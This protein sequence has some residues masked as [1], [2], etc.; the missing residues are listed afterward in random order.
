[1]IAWSAGSALPSVARAGQ[2]RR[3]GGTRR[4][5]AGG[6]PVS[7]RLRA[8]DRHRRRT[9]G[10]DRDL[11][12]AVGSRLKVG[13]GAGGGTEH[14]GLVR[15][16]HESVGQRF[17]GGSVNDVSRERGGRPHGRPGTVGADMVGGSVGRGRA[18]WSRRDVTLGEGAPTA[19]GGAGGVRAVVAGLAG[20]REERVAGW[21]TART[22]PVR[23]ARTTSPSTNA[24]S[25][26]APEPRHRRRTRRHRRRTQRHRRRFSAERSLPGAATV[27]PAA[28]HRIV[29]GGRPV[30]PP[31]DD[32]K[33]PWWKS[34]SV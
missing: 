24:A 11:L 5:C 26:T 4:S 25:P 16:R 15:S 9:S 27:G 17:G 3:A 6:G 14:Q 23:P 32:R 13:R 19:K 8:Q 22:P 21:K 10:A 29:R 20:G 30:G 34:R 7:A 18:S 2:R 33:E 1:M 31:R 12:D 28:A